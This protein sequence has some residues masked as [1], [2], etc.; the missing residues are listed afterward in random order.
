MSDSPRLVAICGL[1]GVG[2]S[3][4]ATYITD[5]IDARRLRTDELRQELIDDPEYTQEER[6]A[7]YEYLYDEARESLENGESVVVDATFAERRHREAV[8]EIAR[9][10]GVEFRL[11]RVVCDRQIVERRIE[12][13]DDIS[14][15]DI[16]T[17]RNYREKF[18]EI[19]TDYETIDN[20]ETRADT[21]AQV[22]AL[23]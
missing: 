4:V 15:A 21:R 6:N 10:C 5:E 13:R 2:K 23:L 18:D 16:E 12:R 20:S 9:E 1:P 3:T 14:D 7:V 11:L 22:D 19:D 17:Y 8:R